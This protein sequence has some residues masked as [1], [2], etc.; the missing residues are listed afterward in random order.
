MSWVSDSTKTNEYGDPI[1]TGYQG[2]SPNFY[3]DYTGADG[4]FTPRRKPETMKTNQYGDPEGRKYM[5]GSPNF[6]GDYTG[7][8]GT[9]TPGRKSD[10]YG[11]QAADAEFEKNHNTPMMNKY[12]GGSSGGKQRMAGDYLSDFT[13][14]FSDNTDY[15]KSEQKDYRNGVRNTPD[16]DLNF[17]PINAGQGGNSKTGE[18]AAPANKGVTSV[19]GEADPNL[20]WKGGGSGSSA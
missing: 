3:R 12:Q 8:D 13:S 16:K 4:T 7:A 17:Q 15:M 18:S 10:Q 11:F 20:T 19:I 1:G 9:F 5:G 2:G 6:Y 14:R